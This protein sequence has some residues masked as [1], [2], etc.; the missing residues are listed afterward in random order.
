MPMPF[1]RSFWALTLLLP[2]A[3]KD[4]EVAS[5]QAAE[6]G[7]QAKLSEGRALLA[8]G[9]AGQ[10]LL[11][12]KAASALAPTEVEPL[13][14]MAEAHRQEGRYGP[15]ILA[16]KQA[17]ALVPGTDAAIQKQ[18][19]D[20]YRREGHPAQAVATWVELRDAH[21][22]KDEEILMLARMQARELRDTDGAFKTLEQIQLQR[23]DD[24]EAKL[25]E[26]EILLLK[27]DELLGAKLMDRLLGENPGLTEAR[28]MRARYFFNNGYASEAEKDLGE[29]KAADANRPDVVTLRARVLTALG[30]MD[31][32]EAA[33]KKAVEADPNDADALAQLAELQLEQGHNPEAQQLVD[34]ALRVRAR[35]ARALYVRGRVLEAKGD[36]KGAEEN[37][38]YALSSDPAFAP[39]LSHVWRMYQE[40]GRKDDAE[41]ALERLSFLGEASLEEKVALA[42]SYA[43]GRRQLER[44]RKLMEEALRREPD[45]KRYKA[46]KDALV[47]AS[48]KP[49]ATGPVIM[50]GG[51]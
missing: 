25:C 37:Y 48:P 47:K 11:A 3:C 15:A 22:L 9:E 43:K 20:L 50:R 18:L 31:E 5:T 13:L 27:G 28:L 38:R 39:V 35:F 24:V 23:P 41:E 2:L 12:F 4:P 36:M 44:G 7:A 8:N 30:R 42:E 51:R 34:K 29:V 19:A 14:L 10:A 6:S 16:L 40:A 26:A 32:A 45:N 49:K 17:E 21:Q 1:S 46:I 33:L